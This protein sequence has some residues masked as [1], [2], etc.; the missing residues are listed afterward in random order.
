MYA[1]RVYALLVDN[2]SMSSQGYTLTFGGN[3][4]PAPA[5][6]GVTLSLDATFTA[7]SRPGMVVEFT[8]D[9]QAQSALAV[10]YHW[11][12]GDDATSTQV[13]PS[14]TYATAGTY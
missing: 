2:F 12:F 7:Q 4:G 13:A 5:P 6:V 11:S 9:V 14:H 8:P 3:C 1:G 10:T